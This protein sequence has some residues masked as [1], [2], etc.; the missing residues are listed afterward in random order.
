MRENT[1]FL[2]TF[3]PKKF[4]CS[5]KIKRITLCYD[6]FVTRIWIRSPKW[7]GSGSTSL[8]K[9]AKSP[10]PPHPV[11]LTNWLYFIHQLVKRDISLF[12][13][14]LFFQLQWSNSLHSAWKELFQYSC[15]SWKLINKNNNLNKN[16]QTTTKNDKSSNDLFV[17]YTTW[18]SP[19]SVLADKRSTASKLV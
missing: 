14:I 9:A 18:I 11:G 2:K 4:W 3:F 16:I 5:W 1:K 6:L 13:M 8:L 17:H 15:V 7:Y 19:A 12:Y 10:S